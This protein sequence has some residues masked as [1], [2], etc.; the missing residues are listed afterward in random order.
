MI[1][2]AKSK[3]RKKEK[4]G[5]HGQRNGRAIECELTHF[6]RGEADAIQFDA[7]CTDRADSEVIRKVGCGN[8]LDARLLRLW[9]LNVGQATMLELDNFD[10][11][12]VER[13]NLCK[14]R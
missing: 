10:A 8:G 12:V 9:A 4:S 2:Q 11:L 3:E 5:P 7:V 13:G 6:E 1:C 14:V